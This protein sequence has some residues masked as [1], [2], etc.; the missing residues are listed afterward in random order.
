[1]FSHKQ[2][3]LIVSVYVGDFKLVGKTETLKAGWTLITCSGSVFGPPT[4]LGDYLGYG[5]FP[6]HV[7]PSEAQRRLDHVR[8]LLGDVYAQNEVIIWT[9]VRAIRYNMF[10]FFRQCVEL[11]CELANVDRRSRRKVATPGMDDH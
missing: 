4:P 3:K 8:P 6:G 5:Q 7:R 10:G 2:L 1:M 11:F 9:P